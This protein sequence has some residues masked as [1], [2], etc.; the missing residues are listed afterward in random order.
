M[1]KKQVVKQ[2]ALKGWRDADEALRRIGEID[3]CVTKSELAMNKAIEAARERHGGEVSDLLEEKKGLERD[4]KA[5]AESS[6]NDFEGRQS[7]ELVH[8]VV[9]FRRSRRLTVHSEANT[10]EAVKRLFPT[11]AAQVI[12]VRESLNK[13]SLEKWGDGDLAAVGVTAKER[14]TFGYE[15]RHETLDD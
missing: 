13:E 3:R 8:G 1:G 15:T 2:L 12:V 14:E 7:K 11:F 4:L 5:F 9:S 10:I 6:R